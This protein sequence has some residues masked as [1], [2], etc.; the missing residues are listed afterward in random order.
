M[1]DDLDMYNY[2][3]GGVKHD[4]GKLRY[5]LIPPDALAALAYVYTIGAKKYDDWNWRKG[6][7]WS[8][9]YGALMRHLIAWQ[10][11]ETYDRDDGQEH[12]AAVAWCAFTLM[13]YERLEVGTDDRPCQLVL[14]GGAGGD[15]SGFEGVLND[16]RARGSVTISKPEGVFQSLRETVE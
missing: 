10:Q 5:E 7:S 1:S 11:G 6:M 8:R 15:A 13:E 12:L 2:R 9:V 3:P 16:P 4:D 14:S